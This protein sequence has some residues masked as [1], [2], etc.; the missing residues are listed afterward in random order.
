MSI[1]TRWHEVRDIDLNA[2]DR[3]PS[4]GQYT[5]WSDLPGWGLWYDRVTGA[6]GLLRDDREALVL[7]PEEAF[8]NP[9]LRRVFEDLLPGTGAMRGLLQ[10]EAERSHRTAVTRFRIVQPQE[11]VDGLRV[12]LR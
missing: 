7:L 10:L 12:V 4:G 9:W 5:F 11:S 1:H 8:Q 6:Y 3:P 2:E